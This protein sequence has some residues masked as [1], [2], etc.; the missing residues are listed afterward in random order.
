MVSDS[1]STSEDLTRKLDELWQ[2]YLPTMQLRL[3]SIQA[4]VESL[5][6]GH[7][8]GELNRKAAYEAHKLAGSLGTFGLASTSAMASESEHLLSE[9]NSSESMAGELRKL[10]DSIKRDIES[11]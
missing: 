6:A 4:A 8:D 3:A 2:R 9:A 1:M 11:R 5:E 10:F 7:V